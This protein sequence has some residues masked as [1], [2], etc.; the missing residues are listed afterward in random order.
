MP[1]PFHPYRSHPRGVR[2]PRRP[3][4][5]RIALAIASALA[6]LI[7]ARLFTPM[8]FEPT[9][10]GDAEVIGH[11]VALVV[12]GGAMA[13]LVGSRRIRSDPR[14]RQRLKSFALM[15][16][17]LPVSLLL[18]REP[19]ARVAMYLAAL[20]WLSV[21]A[22]LALMDA[23]GRRAA[24]P[25]ELRPVCALMA[26]AALLLVAT[27]VAPWQSVVATDPRSSVPFG[28]DGSRV[29]EVFGWEIAF[30]RVHSLSPWVNALPLAAS[31]AGL[32]GIAAALVPA[33]PST[34]AWLSLPSMV[35]ILGCLGARGRLYERRGELPSFFQVEPPDLCSFW[36][37][38]AYGYLPIAFTASFVVLFC[39]LVCGAVW[40]RSR[41]FESA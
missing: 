30:G 35:P 23:L 18:A 6:I 25:R 21:F 27:L 20:G 39:G 13:L 8:W 2:W 26:S 15:V 3:R 41:R 24:S 10:L 16:A 32:C 5:A 37:P 34:R 4:C 33:R 22:G 12:G 7:S 31:F 9:D 14:G 40:L 11:V 29:G 38:G 19:G 36:R 28:W 17:P 1:A